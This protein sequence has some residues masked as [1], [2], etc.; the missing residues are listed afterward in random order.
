M[1]EDKQQERASK[2]ERAAGAGAAGKPAGAVFAAVALVV[3]AAGGWFGRGAL[4]KAEASSTAR[5]AASAAAGTADPCADWSS[6]LC[7]RMGEESEGCEKAKEAA[8]VLPGSAC[9]TAKADLD[10]T[11][12]KLKAAR[13]SCDTLVEKLCKDLG[14]KSKTCAMVR[15]K[16]QSFPTDRCKE[17]LDKY[18]EVVAGLRDMAEEDAPISA[19]LAKRHAASDAPAFGPADAKLTIVEYSDFQCPYCGRAAGIV[20]KLKEKYGTK[21]RFVFRQFP[22]EMHQNAEL[23]AEAA[24]AAHAQG[25][26]WPFHDLLFQNQR[27]LER[28]SLEKYA[29]QAGL[30]MA[31]FKKALDEHTYESAVKS[32]MKLAMEAH[33]A[34]T[35]SMFIGTDRVENPTDWE[36]LSHDIDT[37]LAVVN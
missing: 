27:E 3:G 9:T 14:D 36:S 25:K 12:A 37:R 22:L 30:D 6:D 29:Q 28:P 10:A 35:P 5:P 31:K 4:P 1:A 19:D 33:V 21:V 15:E 20:G 32:D 23:A 11:V 26:F 13:K 18:D 34:G 7:K 8:S 16:T 17:M 2:R 24:L